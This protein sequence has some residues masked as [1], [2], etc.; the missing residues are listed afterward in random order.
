[1]DGNIKDVEIWTGIRVP[2]AVTTRDGRPAYEITV[3]EDYRAEING[4][5]VTVMAS[6]DGSLRPVRNPWFEKYG[7]I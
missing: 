4:R 2:A 5:Q 7:G 3:G 1:M 6:G